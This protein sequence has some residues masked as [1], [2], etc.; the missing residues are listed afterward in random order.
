MGLLFW[1]GCTLIQ[2]IHNNFEQWKP[3]PIYKYYLPGRIILATNNGVAF[4]KMHVYDVLSHMK[5]IFATHK[6]FLTIY[7]STSFVKTTFREREREKKHNKNWCCVVYTAVLKDR[8]SDNQPCFANKTFFELRKW[9][10]VAH[11]P[12]YPH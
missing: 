3:C 7:L 2:Y 11:D 9:L 4:S 6:K 8:A 5:S 12:K 10:P 1:K